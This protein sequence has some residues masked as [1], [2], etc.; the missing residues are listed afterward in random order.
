MKNLLIIAAL[1]LGG[2][3]GNTMENEL[4]IGDFFYPKNSQYIT[5]HQVVYAEPGLVVSRSML[6]RQFVD[7][8]QKRYLFDS[9]NLVALSD[10]AVS[11]AHPDFDIA[12][13]RAEL[14]KTE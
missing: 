8:W 11:M 9:G 5:V 7:E 6:L 13:S 2:C 3:G 10:K 4:K 12:A 1:V 14:E